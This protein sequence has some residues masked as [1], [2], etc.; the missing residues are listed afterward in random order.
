MQ[1]INDPKTSDP[2]ISSTISTSNTSTSTVV[3]TYYTCQLLSNSV[4]HLFTSKT[5]RPVVPVSWASP[6]PEVEEC[7]SEIVT[8]RSSSISWWKKYI[9]STM[10]S[11]TVLTTQTTV[12][13]VTETAIETTIYTTS[14]SA[15]TLCDGSPRVDV[16]PVTSTVTS[17]VTKSRTLVVPQEFAFP[18]AQPCI[19][20]S[21]TCRL[22][23]Y[24]SNMNVTNDDE[25]LQQCG[26]LTGLYEPCLVAG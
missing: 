25:L 11:N 10:F 12:W 21:R 20:D 2:T 15:Y 13:A 8:W 3:V 4:W 16:R 22:W 18:E 19:P 5:E 23:Y 1:G 6:M 7:W 14:V 17:N 24:E 26:R 9:A